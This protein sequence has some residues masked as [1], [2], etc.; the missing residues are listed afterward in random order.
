MCCGTCWAWPT[1]CDPQRRTPFASAEAALTDR[2]SS[3]E[4]KDSWPTLDSEELSSP[5]AFRR[6][7]ERRT[8]PPR[9]PRTRFACA[10]DRRQ[11]RASPP[12]HRGAG[13]GEGRRLFCA[14][15]WLPP[16]SAAGGPSLAAG[17][18]RARAEGSQHS[19]LS[20]WA[21]SAPGRH[22]SRWNFG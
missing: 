6:R 21:L 13:I 1:S 20:G 22:Q 3:I 19:D 17:A 18:V 8:E 5:A 7:R 4:S 10:D 9:Q 2:N 12:S 16:R 14:I 11:R 15:E